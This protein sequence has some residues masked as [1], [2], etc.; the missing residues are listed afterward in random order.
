MNDETANIDRKALGQALRT[1]RERAGMTQKELAQ[2]AG[3]GHT[4]V[5]RVEAGRIDAGWSTLRRLL[6][7]LDASPRQLAEAITKAERQ[8]A[9]ERR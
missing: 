6:R 3:T 8:E 5:S 7:A 4:Y 9:E 2:R 1:L